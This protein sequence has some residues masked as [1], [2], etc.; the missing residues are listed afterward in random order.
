MQDIVGVVVSRV[1]P[2]EYIVNLVLSP[3]GLLIGFSGSCM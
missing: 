3:M 2:H 1:L